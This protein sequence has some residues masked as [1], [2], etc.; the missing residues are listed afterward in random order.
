MIHVSFDMPMP[1]RK[2]NNVPVTARRRQLAQHDVSSAPL[3]ADLG[4]LE[5]L[6]LI[7]LERSSQNLVRWEIEATTASGP[8]TLYTCFPNGRLVQS[9]DRVSAALVRQTEIQEM[10]VLQAQRSFLTTRRYRDGRRDL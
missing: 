9:F 5:P 4:I 8:Y 6:A 7:D 2:K 3:P 1:S 10:L